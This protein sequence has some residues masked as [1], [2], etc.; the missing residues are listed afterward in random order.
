MPG[1]YWSHFQAALDWSDAEM[2]LEGAVQNRW[3]VAEMQRNR[4]ETLGGLSAAAPH[5]SSADDDLDDDA[6]I[7]QTQPPETISSS[8][9]EVHDAVEVEQ[10]V[11]VADEAVEDAADSFAD[12]SA[13]PVRPFASL[14]S[15]PADVQDAFEAFKLAIVR[16]RAAAWG[17]ISREDIVA[18]LDSLREF[19]LSPAVL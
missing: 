3:S 14:P 6:V 18:V 12:T 17:E 2:W 1:L 4:Q 9:G 5:D 7:D 16:H 11:A 19:A 10:E 13:E 8:P 15:L